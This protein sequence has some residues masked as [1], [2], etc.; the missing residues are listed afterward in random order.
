MFSPPFS[1]AWMD[2]L[3]PSCSSSSRL[4]VSLL[5]VYTRLCV[6]PP[7]GIPSPI[8]NIPKTSDGSTPFYF[9]ILFFP[10]QMPSSQSAVECC[11]FLGL[12]ADLLSKFKLVSRGAGGSV[13][14]RPPWQRRVGWRGGGGVPLKQSCLSHSAIGG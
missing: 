13:S 11:F 4:V 1:S 14:S 10:F 12:R 6:I 3:S 5:T 2:S 7:R 9:Y 8:I